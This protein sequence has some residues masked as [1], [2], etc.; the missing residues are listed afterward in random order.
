MSLVSSNSF[1]VVIPTYN[2]GLLWG[3]VIESLLMQKLRPKLILVIDS[4]SKDNT[5]QA[6]KDAGFECIS[7]SQKDFN[8]GATR[9]LGVDYVIRSSKNIKFIVFLTQ[10][11]VLAN[12][13]SLGN[14]VKI[15][16]DEK[17]GAVCGR[18]IPHVN[19]QPLEAH[20]RYFNYSTESKI[21]S[22]EDI[23]RYGIKTAFMSNSF[24][25]YNY[26]AYKDVNGFPDDTIFA[27]DMSI[28]AKMLLKGYKVAYC[29]EASVYHSHSYTII[30]EFR[31]Y[32]DVGVFYNRESWIRESFGSAGGE[33]LKFVISEIRFLLKSNLFYLIPYAFCRVIA[34]FA[35]FRLGMIEQVLSRKTKLRIGMNKSYWR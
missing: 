1:A 11:A 9:N 16:I 25:A 23:L 31:R 28:A 30:E 4:G 34:K 15:L 6:S 3:K 20:A 22:K 8:H 24:A 18:Q 21:K 7:I 13:N 33:G 5:F 32:F 26:M 17:I 19:A 29:A 14:L 27:E 35:A 2:G 10:D 12:P